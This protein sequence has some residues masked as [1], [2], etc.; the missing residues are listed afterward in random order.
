MIRAA[1]RPADPKNLVVVIS[2]VERDDK[3]I[4]GTK[5]GRLDRH[6][7]RNSLTAT[8]CKALDISDMP[9]SLYSPHKSLKELVRLDFVRVRVKDFAAVTL[10]DLFFKKMRVFRS[11][12]GMHLVLP[13]RPNVQQ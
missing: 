9:D 12:R 7:E 3:V 11:R 1:P 8:K 6:L 5:Y 2:N 4:A 10:A 13:P